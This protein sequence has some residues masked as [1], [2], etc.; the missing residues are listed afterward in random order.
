MAMASDQDGDHDFEGSGY[1]RFER[2]EAEMQVAK[3][4]ELRDLARVTF[5]TIATELAAIRMLN[6]QDR[7]L[8]SET[9]EISEGAKDEAESLF[10]RLLDQVNFRDAK[11][12]AEST[13]D[14]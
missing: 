10:L 1:S 4:D 5:E 7:V 9:A 13:G 6:R 14:E 3:V 11:D 8:G 2:D 12:I